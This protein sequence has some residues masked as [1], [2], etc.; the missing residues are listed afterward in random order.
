MR[1]GWLILFFIPILSMTSPACVPNHQE[2]QKQTN[3]ATINFDA[4]SISLQGCAQAY[5]DLALQYNVLVEV[6]KALYLNNEQCMAELE[7]FKP[8]I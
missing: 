7:K 4:C 8:T 5:E 6:S 2:C 1:K 3:L